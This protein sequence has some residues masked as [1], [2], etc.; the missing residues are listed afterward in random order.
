MKAH[1]TTKLGESCSKTTQTRIGDFLL[2]NPI[3]LYTQIS[4]VNHI[5][6][7][8]VVSS[9]ARWMTPD[10]YGNIKRIILWKTVVYLTNCCL[11]A[12]LIPERT[13]RVRVYITIG[14]VI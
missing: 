4:Q 9:L 3:A 14:I 5:F 6:I 11:Y 7:T 13:Q 1:V 10:W 8:I 12:T 2:S